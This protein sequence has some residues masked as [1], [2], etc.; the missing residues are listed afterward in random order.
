[1]KRGS[2]SH[3]FDISIDKSGKRSSLYTKAG[4]TPDAVVEVDNGLFPLTH[5]IVNPSLLCPGTFLEC[6][7]HAGLALC[8]AGTLNK[9]PSGN[10][11][12][13]TCGRCG[14]DA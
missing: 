13:V 8:P 2:F 11:K 5:E 10:P 9:E 3:S 7:S 12:Q 4:D 1:M 6:P 14:C